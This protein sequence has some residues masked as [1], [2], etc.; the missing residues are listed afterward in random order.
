[1]NILAS[2]V[3]PQQSKEILSLGSIWVRIYSLQLWSFKLPPTTAFHKKVF[4]Q[5]GKYRHWR[6]ATMDIFQHVRTMPII[7]YRS[8][9]FSGEI[10]KMTLWGS[11]LLAEQISHSSNKG[12][13]GSLV[14]KMKQQTWILALIILFYPEY[15]YALNLH[16]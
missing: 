15:N 6:K 16:S 4:K 11:F 3:I 1:M 9:H 13:K 14:L 10:N 12:H 2:I 8:D 7:S 5:S